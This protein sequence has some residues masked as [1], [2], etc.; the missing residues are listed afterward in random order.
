L[1]AL[2]GVLGARLSEFL[3]GYLSRGSDSKPA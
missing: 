3:S 1:S 2:D